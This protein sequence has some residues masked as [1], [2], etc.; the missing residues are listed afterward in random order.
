MTEI[1]TATHL[2]FNNE[3]CLTSM[4]IFTEMIRGTLRKMTC[5]CTTRHYM[6]SKLVCGVLWVQLEILGSFSF[7]DIKFTTMTPTSR[8][9]LWASQAILCA[10]LVQDNKQGE[11]AFWSAWFR[12]MTKT[13]WKESIQDIMSSDRCLM[14]NLLDRGEGIRDM[15]KNFQNGLWIR[16]KG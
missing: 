3:I 7:C 8:Q 1:Q 9:H 14:N 5:K 4:K 15:R 2:L 16:V 11:V 13:I 10:V 12:P 6:T